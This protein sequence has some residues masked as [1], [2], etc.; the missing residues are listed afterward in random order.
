GD[1][2]G[3]LSDTAWAAAVYFGY[4]EPLRTHGSGALQ[5]AS[6]HPL[7]RGSILSAP[8]HLRAMPSHTCTAHFMHKAVIFVIRRGEL[9][10]ASRWCFINTLA[11]SQGPYLGHTVFPQGHLNCCRTISTLAHPLGSHPNSSDH[12]CHCLIGISVYSQDR[13]YSRYLISIP[14]YSQGRL[15]YRCLI[16]ISVFSQG[17][18]YC[19]CLISA[20]TLFQ[21]R[22][23]NPLTFSYGCDCCR[24]LISIPTYSQGHHFDFSIYPQDRLYH[25][26]C[27]I[28]L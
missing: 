12:L 19:C 10:N 17:H 13:P 3:F 14:A 5:V 27:I 16:C 26:R 4:L 25:C 8:F 18:H 23:S 11:F 22:H 21:D 2:A 15:H 20:P 28:S 6:S 24:Y 1:A 9:A 7:L